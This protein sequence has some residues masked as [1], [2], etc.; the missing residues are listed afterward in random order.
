M[1][2]DVVIM[3]ALDLLVQGGELEGPALFRTVFHG[4]LIAE[5]R[6]GL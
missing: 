5:F 4:L 2:P 1:T 6:P 3:M